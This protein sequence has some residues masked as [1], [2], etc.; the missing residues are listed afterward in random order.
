MGQEVAQRTHHFGVDLNIL[1]RT[2]QSDLGGLEGPL[3]AA[4]ATKDAT[5]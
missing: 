2:I 3:R 1:W 4:L 5:A